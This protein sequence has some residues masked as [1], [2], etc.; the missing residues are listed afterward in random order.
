MT[1][2]IS[3][4]IRQP[5]TDRMEPSYLHIIVCVAKAFWWM[6][7]ILVAYEFCRNSTKSS[8]TFYVPSKKHYLKKLGETSHSLKVGGKCER[9]HYSFHLW[10]WGVGGRA[11]HSRL[12]L[13]AAAGTA[14]RHRASLAAEHQ[15]SF[16]STLQFLAVLCPIGLTSPQVAVVR[17]SGGALYHGLRP[18][19]LP[20]VQLV[21]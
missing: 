18:P 10:V 2:H 6:R 1:W 11:C 4:L 21:P 9:G 15:T 12:Y 20:H 5:K 17:G 16:P 13:K 14:W 8:I 7:K 3:H 19:P